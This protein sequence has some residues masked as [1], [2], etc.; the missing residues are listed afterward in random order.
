MP[1][2]LQNTNYHGAVINCQMAAALQSHP[3]GEELLRFE[4]MGDLPFRQSTG[5][6]AANPGTASQF[7]CQIRLRC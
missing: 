4:Q 3:V 7:K 6:R 5:G 2:N 1:K